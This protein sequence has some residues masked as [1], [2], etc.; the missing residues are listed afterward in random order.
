MLVWLKQRMGC[1]VAVL[2]ILVS[3]PA[4][5]QR[6]SQVVIAFNTKGPAMEEK[7]FEVSHVELALMKSHP[8]QLG[9][10][11][12]G[13]TTTLGWENARLVPFVYVMPPADGI[14]EFDF[15]ATPPAD[16]HRR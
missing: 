12:H 5:S 4:Y 6:D 1:V 8:P 11:A 2:L 9:I 13:F 10:R 7:I 3:A 15:V 16:R 14:Y